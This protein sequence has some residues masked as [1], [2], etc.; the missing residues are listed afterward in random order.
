[1]KGD[2]GDAHASERSQ[3]VVLHDRNGPDSGCTDA[4]KASGYANGMYGALYYSGIGV[5]GQ[6]ASVGVEKTG[7]AERVRNWADGDLIST[8]YVTPGTFISG[9]TV[10]WSSNARSAAQVCEAIVNEGTLAVEYGPVCE[11]TLEG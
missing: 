9:R 10:F 2:R 11:S 1:M 6:S 3:T 7:L 5:C 8:R 4:L